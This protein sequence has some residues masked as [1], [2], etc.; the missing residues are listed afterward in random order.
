MAIYHAVCWGVPLLSVVMLLAS[1]SV[2]KTRL[3]MLGHLAPKRAHIFL[4]GLTFYVIP[5]FLLGCTTS[6]SFFIS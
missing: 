5:L 6:T 1:S 2:G 4:A 3:L